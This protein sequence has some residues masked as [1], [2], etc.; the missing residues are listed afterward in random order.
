MAD[1]PPAT[2]ARTPR[3]PGLPAELERHGFNAVAAL[4]AARYDPLVP[5]GW[6]TPD[7]LPG[8]RSA[9]VLGCGGTRFGDAFA[10]S[11]EAAEARHP[12]DGFTR[13]VVHQAALALRT[14]GFE[15]QPLFYWERRAGRFADFVAL[16][17]A[18]GLG[19]PGRLGLLLH[20]DYGPWISLRAVL[21]TARE[22]PDAPEAAGFDPCRDCSAPCASVCPVGAPR[23]LGFDAASCAAATHARESC[24]LRCDARRACVLGRAHAYAEPL[25]RRF[26]AAAVSALEE[27]RA[28]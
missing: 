12:V 8:A 7:L 18:C 2:H 13:R 14:E 9:L 16:G 5:P 22:F 28:G 11:P 20:P 10:R 6:R 15:A 25:E 17:R 24:R 23:E 19:V 27:A 3:P 4:S 1:S 21:L 26:R